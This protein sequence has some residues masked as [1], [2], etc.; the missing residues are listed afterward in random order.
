MPHAAAKATKA[1]ASE[2]TKAATAASRCIVGMPTHGYDAMREAAMAV[3]LEVVALTL[4]DR[5]SRARTSGRRRKSSDL[6]IGKCAG[7][8]Q[9]PKA[10]TGS[11]VAVG[12]ACEILSVR[13]RAN[14]QTHRKDRT[15]DWLAR[16]RHVATHPARELAGNAR[17]RPV[18]PNF[19]AVSESARVNSARSLANCSG[20]IP[21]RYPRP[22]ARSS[23]RRLR[24]YAP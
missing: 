19:R 1:A 10:D 14:R 18:S 13:F 23:C 3:A 6:D 20:A 17:P 22:Q 9:S 15:F 24:P 21:M 16:H 5:R 11:P 4:R 8:H 2:A 12:T 7:E